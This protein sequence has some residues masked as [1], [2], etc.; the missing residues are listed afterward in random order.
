V[1]TERNPTDPRVTHE[2][3]L[4]IDAFGNVTR[5]AAVAY[6]RAPGTGVEPEQLK[7]WATESEMSY[8][9]H[10]G[11]DFYRL[12]LPVETTW[13]RRSTMQP[14][15]RTKRRRRR[16]ESRAG[17]S[18]TSSSSIT[19]RTPAEPRRRSQRSVTPARTRCHTRAT[20]WR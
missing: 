14:T 9:N 13:S 8:I 12:G 18:T 2:M 19:P 6:G 10:V 16:P 15:F 3:V 4:D 20:S 17:S 11:D 1:H 5:K 7:A